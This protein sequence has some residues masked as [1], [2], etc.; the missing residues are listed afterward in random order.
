MMTSCPAFALVLPSFSTQTP[1]VPGGLL[2]FL[3]TVPVLKV[4]QTTHRY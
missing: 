3:G 2:W 1:P 4:P